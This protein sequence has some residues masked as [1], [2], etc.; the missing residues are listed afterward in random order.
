MCSLPWKREKSLADVVSK[1]SGNTHSVV[2]STGETLRV[3]VG[4]D[5]SVCLHGGKG[6][7]VLGSDE[8]QAGELAPSL[9]LDDLCDLGVGLGETLVQD[10]VL[11]E[12]KSVCGRGSVW[13]R[14]RRAT[15]ADWVRT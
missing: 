3:L 7:Q 8:L 1:A 12:S 15:K 11:R 10:L 4:E 5:G 14:T 9:I 6:G 2:A 13:Q